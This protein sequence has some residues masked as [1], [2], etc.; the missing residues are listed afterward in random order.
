M[1]AQTCIQCQEAITNPI[2]PDCIEKEIIAWLN[3]KAPALIPSIENKGNESVT[4]WVTRCIVCNNKMGL[5]GHC[6]TKD[7]VEIIR[8]NK[9]RMLEE[10]FVNL[11]NFE[12]G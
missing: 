10:E 11:F 8:N 12:L 5:C 6:Y 9:N 4:A 3:D 1:R 7:V 2:C